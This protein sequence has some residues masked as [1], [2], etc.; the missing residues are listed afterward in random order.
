MYNS[1]ENV[2]EKKKRKEKGKYLGNALSVT[3]LI[4]ENKKLVMKIQI[5]NEPICISLCV[6]ALGET[7]KSICSYSKHWVN[8][9]T[10][11]VF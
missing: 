4:V 3:V 8:C 7:Y 10:D 9:R 1:Y 11:W 5:L 6:F 2:N